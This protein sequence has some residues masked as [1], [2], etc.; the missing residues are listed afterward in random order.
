MFCGWGVR[1][2]SAF[3]RAYNPISYHDGSVWP[4]DNAMIVEGLC[5]VGHSKDGMR[6]MNGM[7]S[8]AQGKS[9]LRLPEL[10]CGFSKNFS[11]PPVWYP[12]SCEPQAWAAGSMFLMLKSGLGLQADALNKKLN[13]VNPTLPPFLNSVKIQNLRVGTGKVSLEFTRKDDKTDCI[14]SG[15][16]DDLGVSVQ[17]R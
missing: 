3:E 9:N 7:F 16:P 17:V 13:V 15:K 8:A 12:V 11:S 6:I 14:V 2:L 4:H 10:F 5:K 1:T